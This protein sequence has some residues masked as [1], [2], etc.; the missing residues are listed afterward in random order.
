MKLKKG[1]KLR[2]IKFPDDDWSLRLNLTV[3]KTYTV[4]EVYGSHIHNATKISFEE[5][6]FWLYEYDLFEK[7][8]TNDVTEG[9]CM[10]EWEDI[11]CFTFIH[12]NCKHC[13]A[14]REEINC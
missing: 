14:K 1:D 4:R 7:A 10:H 11:V 5:T 9:K 6:G 2:C 12:Q 3:G 8:H 13:G